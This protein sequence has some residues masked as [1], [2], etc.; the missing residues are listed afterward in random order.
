MLLHYRNTNFKAIYSSFPPPVFC[1]CLD[2]NY[3]V[4]FGTEFHNIVSRWQT[5]IESQE[6]ARFANY[7][8]T[9]NSNPHWLSPPHILIDK[10][11]LRMRGWNRSS[12]VK[13]CRS[14]NCCL[15]QAKNERGKGSVSKG[16]RK[17]S[18]TVIKALT[19]ISTK[20]LSLLRLGFNAVVVK[21][22]SQHVLRLNPPFSTEHTNEE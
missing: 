8:H 20:Q 7:R 17:C 22:S 2:L 10:Q 21:K 15:F 18:E 19:P 6:M 13:A 16:E 11:R 1:Y 4:H 12:R 14:V 3:M 5:L 9:Q